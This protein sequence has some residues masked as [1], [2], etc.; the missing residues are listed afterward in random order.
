MKIELDENF[1]EKA[2]VKVSSTISST[3]LFDADLCDAVKTL[4]DLDSSLKYVTISLN[5]LGNACEDE[6]P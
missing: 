3:E 5:A 6:S 4:T 2:K 1:E